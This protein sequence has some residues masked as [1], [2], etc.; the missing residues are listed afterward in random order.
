MRKKILFGVFGI[1]LIALIFLMIGTGK[2]DEPVSD[3]KFEVTSGDFEVLVVV[4]GELQ[5]SSATSIEGPSE[6]RSRNLRLNDIVIQDL[7]TEGTVVDSGDWVAELDRSEIDNTLKDVLDN[8]ELAQ[9]SMTSIRL[10]T[11]IQLTQLREN[12]W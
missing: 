9:S 3:N 1:A 12:Y 6:L 2:G 8:L 5:A 10:D 7:I 4:S 11:T